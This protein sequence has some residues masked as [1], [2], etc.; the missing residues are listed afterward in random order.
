MGAA[1]STPNDAFWVARVVKGAVVDNR[2]ET[3]GWTNLS[4]VR[5][6][7]EWAADVFFPR[8]PHPPLHNQFAWLDLCDQEKGW[9]DVSADA[10]FERIVKQ[11]KRIIFCAARPHPKHRNRK[12]VDEFFIQSF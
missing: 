7:M 10:D 8:G 12:L 9:H 4:T 5:V 2:F 1:F 6:F 11:S 3:P